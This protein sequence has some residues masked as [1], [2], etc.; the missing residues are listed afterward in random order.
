MD[1]HERARLVAAVD[2]AIT[3]ASRRMRIGGEP[4]AVTVADVVERAADDGLAVTAAAAAEV[5]RERFILRGGAFGLTTD[6]FDSSVGGL[7]SGT[8]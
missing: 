7:A 5:L 8:A 1:G 4:V 6:A 2:G 3:T